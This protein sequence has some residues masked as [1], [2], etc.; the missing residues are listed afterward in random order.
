MSSLP[1][2]DELNPIYRRKRPGTM[3]RLE[4]S[5]VALQEPYSVSLQHMVA[6]RSWNMGLACPLLSSLLVW[7][8]VGARERSFQYVG[9]SQT[10]EVTFAVP[11]SKYL[12]F[13]AKGILVFWKLPFELIKIFCTPLPNLRRGFSLPTSSGAL[14]VAVSGQLT[15]DQWTK[16]ATP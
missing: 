2:T 10:S 4:A 12:G 14:D 7:V 13:R 3:Q 11:E 16:E 8:Y 6:P 5:G 15:R 1:L 9:S